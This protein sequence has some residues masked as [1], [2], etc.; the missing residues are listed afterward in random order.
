MGRVLGQGQQDLQR[1][2]VLWIRVGSGLE[3]HVQIRSG[4]SW[5]SM[6]SDYSLFAIVREMA[7]WKLILNLNRY[8]GI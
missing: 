2:S 6:A 5:D 4:G 3:V 7:T 1:S 8:T